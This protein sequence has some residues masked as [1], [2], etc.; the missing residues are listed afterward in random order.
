MRLESLAKVEHT[1][2]GVDNSEENEKNGDNG[3]CG[4]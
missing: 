2:N 4:Q 3:E 1:H